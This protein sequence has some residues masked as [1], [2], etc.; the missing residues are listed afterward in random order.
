MELTF[1]MQDFIRGDILQS[2]SAQFP[3]ELLDSNRLKEG[4]VQRDRIYNQENTLLTMLTAAFQE[5]KSLENSV[6]VFSEIFHNRSEQL[7]SEESIRLQAQREADKDNKGKIG[8][9]KSY[10]PKLAKSKSR[11]ISLN[12][13]AYSKARKRLDIG[14][15]QEV[16]KHSSQCGQPVLWHGLETYIGDGT[17][18]QM[19]DTLALRSKYFVKENDGA[20]PQGLLET[21]VRQGSGQIAYFKIG[22]RHQSELE[23]YVDLI[24][25][26]KPG[27]LLLA[28]DLYSCYAIFSLAIQRGV[29]LIVPGKRKRSYSVIKEIAPGDQIV[30]LKKKDLPRWWDKS[31]EIPDKLTMRR[32]SYNSPIDGAEMVLYTTILDENVPKTDFITKYITRWDVEISIREIKTLMGLN[33]ARGKSEEMVFKEM[34]I[35]LTAYNMA[36]NLIAKAVDNTG[37]PP[38]EHIFQKFLEANKTVLIDK[39]GRVYSRWSTGRHGKV[40]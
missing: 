6:Q 1:R 32:I 31:F 19:Q 11:D 26:L 7:K 34:L 17:Y 24:K 23:L 30:E 2:L 14:L 39:K 3:F 16:F 4:K 28:D 40:D 13:A 8:R 27:S 25:E 21:F 12:T 36:R 15:V 33:I 37:F 29:H 38:Q 35:G 22:T 18:F 10:K 5:D 20:Y 9:P